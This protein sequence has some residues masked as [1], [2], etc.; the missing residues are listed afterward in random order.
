LAGALV[1]KLR[2]APRA[3]DA[4]SPLAEPDRPEAHEEHEEDHGLDH[5]CRGV[6][7]MADYPRESTHSPPTV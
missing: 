6:E 5:E 1:A 7:V 2:D 3:V 4:A